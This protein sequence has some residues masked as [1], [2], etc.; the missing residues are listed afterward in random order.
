VDA[1]LAR[2][3]VAECGGQVVE[4]PPLIE[5]EDADEAEPEPQSE[6]SD[7]DCTAAQDDGDAPESS[8]SDHAVGPETAAT[9]SD[10]GSGTAPASPFAAEDPKSL[11]G[12]HD[13]SSETS[14]AEA[15]DHSVPQTVDEPAVV[16]DMNSEPAT[17][18]EEPVLNSATLARAF[19][20]PHLRRLNRGVTRK[21]EH[22]DA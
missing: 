16:P 13:H 10:S 8:G 20:P 17:A 14:E 9:S 3:L 12:H 15:A 19:P 18:G 1:D 22:E 7:H 21:P 4:L 11:G 2:A 6:A 5:S